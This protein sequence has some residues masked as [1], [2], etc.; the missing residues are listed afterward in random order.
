MDERTV[1]ALGASIEEAVDVT[2]AT[3][4]AN[5]EALALILGALV[6]KARELCRGYR[7]IVGES[8]A[9]GET[10]RT[11]AEGMVLF[12]D[13]GPTENTGSDGCGDL[14]GYLVLMTPTGALRA[15]EVSGRYWSAQGGGALW[16]A[17]LGDATVEE[18]ATRVRAEAVLAT[19]HKTLDARKAHK[20]TVWVRQRIAQ[21]FRVLE[22]GARDAVF[23]GDLRDHMLVAAQV[24]RVIDNPL[25]ALVLGVLRATLA[26]LERAKA[27]QF[28]R[29]AT[30]H[31]DRYALMKPSREA[32]EMVISAGGNLAR[33]LVRALGAYV[34]EPGHAGMEARQKE[35]LAQSEL[36]AMSA[37][38]WLEYLHALVHQSFAETPVPSPSNA[39]N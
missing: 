15:G 26:P 24:L 14:V 5:V 20:N 33:V 1:E 22:E 2:T 13:Y 11:F 23:P 25:A 38:K 31:A 28:Q 18:V 39:S 29:E 6:P 17:D 21:S 4:T 19:V 30:V 8:N 32:P 37:L 36:A 16:S 7:A 3:A 9:E 12:V 27:V 35:L 10:P 34:I